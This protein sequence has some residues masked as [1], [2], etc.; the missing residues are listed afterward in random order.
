MMDSDR[1]E[2]GYW[3]T[4]CERCG[5]TSGRYLNP[6]TDEERYRLCPTCTR[7]RRIRAYDAAAGLVPPI[8]PLTI[9]EIGEAFPWFDRCREMD[10]RNKADP[11]RV[12]LAAELDAPPRD[13]P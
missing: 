10:E 2:M 3:L 4:E 8:R 6:P 11:A 5:Q 12:L 9:A 1:D 7:E 13:M